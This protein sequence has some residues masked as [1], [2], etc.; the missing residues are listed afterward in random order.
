MTETIRLNKPVG[1]FLIIFLWVLIVSLV[2]FMLMFYFQTT[3]D[4]VQE[5]KTYDDFE[6]CNNKN[7]GGDTIKCPSCNPEDTPLGSIEYEEQPRNCLI[8][9][10]NNFNKHVAIIGWV[11]L[12]FGICVLLYAILFA[13]LLFKFRK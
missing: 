13:F 5:C 7:K 4:V 8:N 6:K 9:K 10:A 2:I 3:N 11:Y 12:V 1:Y